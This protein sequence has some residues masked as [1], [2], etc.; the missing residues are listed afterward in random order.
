[1]RDQK[2]ARIKMEK[3]T[4]DN[5]AATKELDKA[6][7]AAAMAQAKADTSSRLQAAA[8]LEHHKAANRVEYS[9][10]EE[11]ENSEDHDDDD[12]EDDND[13]FERDSKKRGLLSL[14]RPVPIS[15]ASSLGSMDYGTR[16]WQP[17]QPLM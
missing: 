10:A 6:K 17:R 9:Q 8:E 1:M 14:S 5:V 13:E 7:E 15:E 4:R 11:I 12:D 2:A 3:T 16:C